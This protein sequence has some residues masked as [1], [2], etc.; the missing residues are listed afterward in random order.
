MT[1]EIPRPI[2][3]EQYNQFMGGVDKPDQYLA[4]HNVLHKTVRYW[5]TLFYHMI[6][7]AVVNAFVLITT[8]LC[9][10]GVV[11]C[12]RTTSVMS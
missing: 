8:S 12:L 11:L 3:I 10:L 7:V 1:T 9:C 5:K 6:D 4:Y 2:P